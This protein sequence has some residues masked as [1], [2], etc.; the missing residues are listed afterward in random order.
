MGGVLRP[1]D[2][3]TDSTV[4]TDNNAAEVMTGKYQPK[5]K[6]HCYTLE[7]Y[8]ETPIFIPLDITEDVVGS[9]AW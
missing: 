4:F 7:A 8:K 2:R 9:V 1:G 6:P 5:R 3:A